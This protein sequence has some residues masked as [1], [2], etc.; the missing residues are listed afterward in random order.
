MLFPKWVWQSPK[1]LS[2]KCGARD[3][4]VAGTSS[5]ARSYKFWG[6]ESEGAIIVKELG[7]DARGGKEGFAAGSCLKEETSH[8][9]SQ[10]ASSRAPRMR[11]PL[12]LLP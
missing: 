5:L 12:L 1:H 11:L 4:N 3:R 6:Y 2:Y 8:D 9:D 10:S 7:A